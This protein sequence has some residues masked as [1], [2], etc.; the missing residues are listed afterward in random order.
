MAGSI[1]TLE[2]MEKIEQMLTRCRWTTSQLA[3]ELNVHPS[4]VYRNIQILMA[5]GRAIEYDEDTRKGR[6]YWIRKDTAI[7]RV[8]VTTEEASALYVAA[9][10]LA[11]IVD[12]SNP[13][14]TS[15]LLKLAEPLE[16]TAPTIA[17]QIQR[18]AHLLRVRPSDDTSVETFRVLAQAWLQSRKVRISYKSQ[19]RA[20]ERTLSPYLLEPLDTEQAI[21]VVGHDSDSDDVRTFKLDRITSADLLREEFEVPSE[22]DAAAYLSSA[23]G[24]MGA[25]AGKQV[26]RVVLH[27]GPEVAPEIRERYWHPTQQLRDVG[28]Q[29]CILEVT[30]GHATEMLRWIRRWGLHNV[31]VLEPPALRQIIIAEAQ[32]MIDGYQEAQVGS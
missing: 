21:Y 30:V 8:R 26:E 4:T 9:R 27:F 6:Q 18:A 10:L 19:H 24:I 28:D 25:D 2:R 12:T 31:R 3:E 23:W 5:N 17:N 1:E 14:V 22:F 11:R 20:S 15:A 29:G 13:I 32:A 7:N 16:H